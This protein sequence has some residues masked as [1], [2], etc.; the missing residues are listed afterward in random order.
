[1]DSTLSCE[2]IRSFPT[3]YVSTGGNLVGRH[4]VHIDLFGDVVVDAGEPA[5]ASTVAALPVPGSAEA[6]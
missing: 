3:R 6:F 5:A 1:M 2:M 4:L